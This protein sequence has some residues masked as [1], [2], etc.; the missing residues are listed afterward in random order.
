MHFYGWKKGLKTGM[1]YL[2]TPPAAQAT[3]SNREFLLQ[4]LEHIPRIVYTLL[5]RYTRYHKIGWA[6]VVVWDEAHLGKFGSHYLKREFYFD[7]HPPLGK[8]L[9]GLAGLP[10]GYDGSF[11]FKSGVQYP[12]TVP[13]HRRTLLSAETPIQG[14]ITAEEEEEEEAAAAA[15][16]TTAMARAL[17]R[18][19]P[20]PSLSPLRPRWTCT[21]C[22]CDLSFKTASFSQWP[23]LDCRTHQPS[24]PFPTSPTFVSVW[25]LKC[26]HLL[27]THCALAILLPD[28]RDMHGIH[29]VACEQQIDPSTAVCVKKVFN[30]NFAKCGKAFSIVAR[31][32][33]SDSGTRSFCA[34]AWRFESLRPFGWKH[35]YGTIDNLYGGGY[36]LMDLVT[37]LGESLSHPRP[38][39]SASRYFIR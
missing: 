4:N 38:N 5:S 26:G 24:T 3:T 13:Y 15:D 31:D 25:V 1:Y 32:P 16:A 23:K 37:I 20:T 2:R 33:S 19:S 30:C 12:V 35:Q 17:T 11:E 8:M 39:F 21:W 22:G 29:K 6:N 28:I 7:V 18:N 9:V 10:A 14:A 27:D 34:M 36:D